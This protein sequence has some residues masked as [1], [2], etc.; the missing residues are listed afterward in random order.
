MMF[1]IQKINLTQKE[2]RGIIQE[3]ILKFSHLSNRQ[4][5]EKLG[6]DHKTV[7]FYRSELESRGEIPH[8]DTL[9]REQARYCNPKLSSVE[10]SLIIEPNNLYNICCE[11]GIAIAG[12]CGIKVDLIVSSPPYNVGLKYDRY[13]DNKTY[14]EYINW[15]KK[16]FRDCQ[17][18]MNI[19]GTVAINVGD[20][21][22]GAQ[23]IHSDIIQFMTRELDYVMRATIIW[24][25][26]TVS[27]RTAWGSWMQPSCPSFPTPFEY[28]LLF[29]YKDKHYRKSNGRATVTKEE[30]IENSL[31]LWTFKPEAQFS[32]KHPAPFPLELP[33]RIIQQMTYE[34]DLVLDIFSGTGTTA[35]AS[36]QLNRRYIGFE[37]S[38]DYHG[39][40]MNRLSENQKAA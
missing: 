26:N 18:I 32:K 31:A 30:F 39:I 8:I 12:Q 7:G 16:I 35:L 14:P 24:H 34:E 15:L 21:N 29:R 17:N 28:I 13:Q 3:T 37:L 11:D 36:K 2:K 23:P 27:Q 25:K 9:C 10:N 19:G 22:N 38:A 1:N 4:I 20:G 5:A 33:K 40:A 6:V